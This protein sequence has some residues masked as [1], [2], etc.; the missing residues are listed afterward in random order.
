MVVAVGDTSKSFEVGLVRPLFKT[1]RIL[2]TSYPYDVSTDGK[3]FLV[4]SAPD[5]APPITV[6]LDWTA[7]LSK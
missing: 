4:N 3:R 5:K 2:G 1:R 6:V 7:T